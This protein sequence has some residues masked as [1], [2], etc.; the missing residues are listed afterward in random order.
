MADVCKHKRTV[1]KKDVRIIFGGIFDT[2]EY[3]KITTC[4]NCG[5]I[6]RT[7]VY[8]AVKYPNEWG[9]KLVGTFE[10]IYKLDANGNRTSKYTY[11][12]TPMRPKEV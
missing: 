8:R 9:T 2:R 4:E 5:K 1:V 10:R 7:E 3:I 11:R 12:H 6:I